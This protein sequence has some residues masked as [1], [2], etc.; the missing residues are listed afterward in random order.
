MLVLY[1]GESRAGIMLVRDCLRDFRVRKLDCEQAVLVLMVWLLYKMVEIFHIYMAWLPCEN[2]TEQ[3]EKDRE[4]R[5]KGFETF[6]YFL[7]H[8]IAAHLVFKLSLYTNRR[9]TPY[10]TRSLFNSRIGFANPV[11]WM[12]SDLV[13]GVTM[14]WLSL[15]SSTQGRL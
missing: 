4:D 2:W 11:D 15:P 14:A 8:D 13:K 7:I 9:T 10:A 6:R 3:E 12:L 5:A 1:S